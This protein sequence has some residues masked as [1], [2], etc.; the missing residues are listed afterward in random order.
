VYADAR[1]TDSAEGLVGGYGGTIGT[2]K[3][4]AQSLA[5]HVEHPR[6]VNIVLKLLLIRK[7]WRGL[8]DLIYSKVRP[9]TSDRRDHVFRLRY[10]DEKEI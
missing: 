10:H 4:L 1:V 3:K 2:A 7:H 8:D 9:E 6:R 5:V